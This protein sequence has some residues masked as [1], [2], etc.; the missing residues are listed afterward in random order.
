M[1]PFRYI[2]QLREKTEKKNRAFGFVKWLSVE[3]AGVQS[4]LSGKIDNQET[5]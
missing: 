5:S 1:Q 3:I 4:F 2:G